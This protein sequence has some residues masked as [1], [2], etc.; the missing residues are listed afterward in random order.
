MTKPTDLAVYKYKAY[1][2]LCLQLVEEARDDLAAGH[3]DMAQMHLQ[4]ILETFDRVDPEEEEREEITT[5]NILQ[6]PKKL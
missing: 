6:F 3:Y 5:Q 4:D 1:L 2:E